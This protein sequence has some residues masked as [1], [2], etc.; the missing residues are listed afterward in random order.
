MAALAVFDAGYLT[1]RR[2]GWRYK[3]KALDKTVKNSGFARPHHPS[4]AL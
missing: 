2:K 4:P 3:N 1:N